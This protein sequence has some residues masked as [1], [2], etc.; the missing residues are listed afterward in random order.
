MTTQNEAD[1][2]EID[3][4][5]AELVGTFLDA[6]L[7]T[8]A[9]SG[10]FLLLIAKL[11]A[12]C[13]EEFKEDFAKFL[14]SE[15][16]P[17]EWLDPILPQGSE[18]TI[19]TTYTVGEH[20][21]G[22]GM[23]HVYIARDKRLGRDVALKV[24]K[25]V[26]A[27]GWADTLSDRDRFLSEASITAALTHPSVPA[28]Y[29]VNRSESGGLT[30]YAMQLVDE[31]HPV[32]AAIGK[33]HEGGVR[34]RSFATTEARQLIRHLEG[35]CEA[36]HQA[37]KQ[38]F[39]HRDLKPGNLALDRDGENAWVLDWG[40]AKTNQSSPEMAADDD[41]AGTLPY[42]SPEQ[43]SGRSPC[44]PKSDVY[45]LG[46]I[47]YHILTNNAPFTDHEGQSSISWITVEGKILQG[48]LTPP[49]RMNRRIPRRLDR[50]CRKAMARNPEKRYET[51]AD[52]ARELRLWLDNERPIGVTELW[53]EW[54]HRI[55]TKRYP[56]RALAVAVTLFATI[57]TLYAVSLLR[58]ARADL[59]T[60]EAEARAA[61]AES[62]T[63]EV[64]AQARRDAQ[65][66]EVT[67][68][69]SEKTRAAYDFID[70]DF[71]D[72]RMSYGVD[73]DITLAQVLN[74]A[75]PRIE[76]RYAKDPENEAR[77]KFIV[78]NK[79]RGIGLPK[80]AEPL[81]RRTME[82]RLDKFGADDARTIS[83]Q[84]M[85]AGIIGEA[86]RLDEAESMMRSNVP[87]SLRINGELNADTSAAMVDL[88]SLLLER[89]RKGFS[90]SYAL[91]LPGINN[92]PGDDQHVRL[93]AEDLL[94]QARR[95]QEIVLGKESLRTFGTIN[96]LASS[97]IERQQYAEAEVLLSETAASCKKT[98]TNDHP[99]T[100]AMM[101]NLITSKILGN[102]GVDDNELDEQLGSA[103]KIM[104]HTHP[105]TLAA[106]NNVVTMNLDPD[107]PKAL[108]RAELPA[109]DIWQIFVDKKGPN[110]PDTLAYMDRY[111]KTLQHQGNHRAAEPLVRELVERRRS[112]NYPAQSLGLTLSSYGWTLL[113]CGNT[114]EAERIY[115][116]AKALFNTLNPKVEIFN[117]LCDSALG[118]CARAEQRYDEAE[119]LA[120]SSW[121]IIEGTPGISK[122]TKI[123]AL[124]RLIRLYEGW[125]KADEAANW[126]TKKSQLTN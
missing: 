124:D 30:Y 111:A 63:R 54:V 33:I 35:V 45:S 93:E 80:Q 98:L 32:T 100:I 43:A 44:G 107:K 114:Q 126:R 118:E 116:E 67:R 51:A 71:L 85:L 24:M 76:A 81:A 92:G 106:L 72:S 8:G 5:L 58:T 70:E 39:I 66:A 96:N 56:D 84:I 6:R 21:G 13:P 25:R 112:L 64:A 78:A 17:E 87:A 28:V 57:G 90:K 19:V 50:I 94:K 83:S 65:I 15:G 55:V 36:V 62:D 82:I 26:T 40:L 47:L 12:D 125:G 1:P 48:T 38:G 23:G 46:A 68:Q 117:A 121:P 86:G 53:L 105:F 108:A 119:K 115:R 41:I 123:R 37:H 77:V 27:S 59:R 9:E 11:I 18:L 14:H 88:A 99:M 101:N 22:G 34:A 122:S 42:I 52:L 110:D 16:V 7:Q 2:E 103:R 89:V 10:S 61:K 75:V 20:L 69:E 102:R 4:R 29:G 31:T 3:P 104:G 120:Q 74:R 49:R 60:V 79:Y 97:L 73:P 91:P 109:R 113:E 95:I